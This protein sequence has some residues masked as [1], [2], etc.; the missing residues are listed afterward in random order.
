MILHSF[1]DSIRGW[2]PEEP[3]M[4]KSKLKRTLPPIAVL[5]AATTIVS[6]FSPSAFF[7]NTAVL[8]APP[9]IVSNAPNS[10]FVELG[11]NVEN[12]EG[13][14]LVLSDGNHISPNNLALKLTLTEKSGSDC[15]VQ[16]A[17]ECEDFSNEISVDGSIIDGH[18]II[19][20][21]RSL[22]LINPDVTK[23]QTFLLAESP[24]WTV[25]GDVQYLTS[26]TST[27]IEPYSVTA[28]MVSSSATGTK[29]GWPLHLCLGYEP[30]TGLLVYSGTS[31]SDVLLDKVGIDYL[32]GGLKLVSYSE[33][34]NLK[35]AHR[36][37]HQLS[38]GFILSILFLALLIIAPVVVAVCVF[39]KLR[40]RRRAGAHNVLK[41]HDNTGK[42]C[43]VGD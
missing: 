30:N 38:S 42:N 25:G 19:D 32:L 3:K 6:L 14:I 9:L 17:V 5:V 16:L 33:N 34:L 20:S 22:F 15:T 27:A 11:G 8:A 12:P 43:E 31:L 26:K 39:H 1:I 28:I 4:P 23:R 2:L 21:E 18:L 37:P 35:I 7:P 40:K 10:F 24:G 41:F 13:F 36:Y 29:K